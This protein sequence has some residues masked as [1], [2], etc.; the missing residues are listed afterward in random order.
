MIFLLA[1]I[2]HKFLGFKKKPF[3][4]QYV[5]VHFDVL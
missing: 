2:I 3:S 5:S 1:R 4:K